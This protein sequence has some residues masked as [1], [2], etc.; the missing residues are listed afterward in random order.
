MFRN[1]DDNRELQF[2]A[3]LIYQVYRRLTSYSILG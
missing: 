1:D 2:E 3:D